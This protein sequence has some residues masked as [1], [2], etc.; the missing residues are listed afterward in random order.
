MAPG[1]P[2][3][4]KMFMWSIP[5]TILAIL[6]GLYFGARL[7]TNFAMKQVLGDL[8]ASI[9]SG[10]QYPQAPAMPPIVT[11]SLPEVLSR[12]DKIVQEKSPK[13]A[14]TL[15]PGLSAEQIRG[16]EEEFSVTLTEELRQLYQWHDG[17]DLTAGIPLT[18]SDQ[19]VPLRDVL[20][21]RKHLNQS[22]QAQQFAT[23]RQLAELQKD[24]L[25]ILQ[26]GAGDGYSV[27]LGRQ[28]E[29]GATFYSV[30]DDFSWVF[31]PSLKNLVAAIAECYKTSAYPIDLSSPDA[32]KLWERADQIHTKYGVCAEPPD[33][34]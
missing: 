28:P 8:E 3:K 25:N 17:Q 23:L 14:A 2:A 15:R 21:A 11:E 5:L 12:L 4:R 18:A 10:F 34:E 16:L 29:E 32:T 33:V 26:N 24:R 20:M 30:H 31:Y 9:E 22:I 6:I 27:D 1:K 19:Y 13:T 7:L